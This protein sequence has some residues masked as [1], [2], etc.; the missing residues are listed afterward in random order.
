MDIKLHK[1]A[2]TTPKIRAQIQSAPTRIMNS[3]LARQYDVATATIQRWR[4]WLGRTPERPGKTHEKIQTARMPARYV[5]TSAAFFCFRRIP[6][7][8]DFSPFR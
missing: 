7:L 5:S 8:K 6:P 1:Q 2:A 4:S 3:E